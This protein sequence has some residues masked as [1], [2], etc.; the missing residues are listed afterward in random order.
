MQGERRPLA[1]L[2]VPPGARS[3]RCSWTRVCLHH[4][5]PPPTAPGQ[6]P[7]T[8]SCRNGP[9]HGSPALWQE[10][11]HQVRRELCPAE[12]GPP[13]SA[14]TGAPPVQAKRDQ[15][16]PSPFRRRVDGSLSTNGSQTAPAPERPTAACTSHHPSEAGPPRPPPEQTLLPG[17]R[18]SGANSTQPGGSQR[19]LPYRR[20]PPFSA[21]THSWGQVSEELVIRDTQPRGWGPGPRSAARP[22]PRRSGG[23]PGRTQRAPPP[24]CPVPAW[25]RSPVLPAPGGHGPHRSGTEGVKELSP[26][27]PSAPHSPPPEG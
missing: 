7:H 27:K 1:T 14:K 9:R 13:L 19:Q 10:P 22:V 18:H 23:P 15:V 11:R 21:Q 20:L 6:G 3:G 12:P 16:P 26:N 17:L 2:A 25:Q 8:A 24:P 5:A 4:R